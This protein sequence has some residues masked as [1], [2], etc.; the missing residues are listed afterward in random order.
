MSF[1]SDNLKSAL[2]EWKNLLGDK[3]VLSGEEAQK[4]YAPNEIASSRKIPCALKPQN[5]NDVCAILK[6]ASKYK[7]PL[8]TISVGSNW[9]YGGAGPVEDNCVVMDLSS[10]DKILE[11][12][13][14]LG[15]AT[16]EPG[17]TPK[18]LREYL[19]LHNLPFLVPVSG[20]GPNCSLVGNALERGYGVTPYVD[21][22]GGVTSLE[23]VLPEG[24]IYRGA[25]SSMGGEIVDRAFKWGVGPYLDG[26]FSQANMGI[27]TQMSIAL[28]PIPGGVEAFI[29]ALK[30][31]GYLERSVKEIRE[32][33]KSIGNITGS[34]N[35]MNAHRVLAMVE[36]FPFEKVKKGEV[37]DEELLKTLSTK[38]F[39]GPWTIGGII[40]GDKKLIKFAKSVIKEKLSPICKRKY[41]FSRNKINF[42]KSGASFLPKGI[43]TIE[44]K[45]LMN[46][47]ESFK[48][49][50]GAPSEI[51]LPL[52]YWKSGKR[53]KSG[54]LM[55]PSKDGRGIIWYSPLIPMKS[56][57]VKKYVAMVHSV[58]EKYKIEP[59]ITLTSL[60][61]RCFDS[62]V[63]IL[64]DPKDKDETLR[65]KKC[66]I[67]LFEEGK[68]DGF[69]PYRYG[70]DHM[71]L[72]VN[73]TDPFWKLVSK[74]KNA[75]DPDHILS[76]GRY[77]PK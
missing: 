21:H 30:N 20:A 77:S 36:D 33:L 73:N 18:K 2:K 60:S 66:Y 9:G 6:I 29:F 64:F 15:I 74:I 54:E 43:M 75:L 59:L 72:I 1:N 58:C 14:E 51:A 42:F 50:E 10:M 24:E 49:A 76:P 44:K 5:A 62:T 11:F 35:L 39:I 38:N 8:Y 17:V 46:L 61:H 22:F 63:P 56:E 68:K 37:I 41:F 53:P 28:A 3:W 52:C 16:L 45:Q 23:A 40:Y 48:V 32:I 71:N 27:I 65:A 4:N 13:D 57:A 7:V 69:I 55:D 31:E 25:L 26:I 34:I 47:D 67:A 19:D 70:I 12:D